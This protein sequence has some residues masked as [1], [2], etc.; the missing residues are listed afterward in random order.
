MHGGQL[1]S[2]VTKIHREFIPIAPRCLPAPFL[3]FNYPL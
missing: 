3:T 1:H 2:S